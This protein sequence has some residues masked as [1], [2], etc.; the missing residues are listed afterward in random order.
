[1]RKTFEWSHAMHTF[2]RERCHLTRQALTDEFNTHFGTDRTYDT[3]RSFCKR[4]RYM[5]NRNGQFASGRTSWNKGLKGYYAKGSEAGWFTKNNRPTSAVSVGTRRKTTPKIAADGKVIDSG[6]WKVKIAEPNEWQF[7]HRL[8]WER[9]H[10]P[11]SKGHV[12]IFL[13]G[14][15]DNIVID[16]L[17]LLSRAQLAVLNKFYGGYKS[18]SADE[19]RALVAMAKLQ[20]ATSKREFSDS[21]Q[22]MAE[23]NG[24]SRQ[25]ARS[26]VV[27]GWPKHL[28]LTA[29]IGTR[30]PKQRH[31]A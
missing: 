16:N 2:C 8:L 19:R 27:K 26:R 22:A 5:T 21:D 6:L 20:L 11:I 12:L 25:T 30:R 17:T 14:D 31:S 10:G 18:A 7:E 9:T 15:Q 3:I 28:A 1:M 4:N 29:P 13:D 24:I 23:S